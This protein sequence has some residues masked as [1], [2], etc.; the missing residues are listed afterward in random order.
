MGNWVNVPVFQNTGATRPGI[1]G[2]A[3]YC[4]NGPSRGDV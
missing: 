3:N 4:H 1:K 2:S